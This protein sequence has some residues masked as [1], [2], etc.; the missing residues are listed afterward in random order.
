MI[1]GV[2]PTT[3]SGLRVDAI[4][5]RAVVLEAVANALRDHR[6]LLITFA[7]PGTPIIA[8]RSNAVSLFDR[9]DIVAAD[10]IAMVQGM[11]WLHRLPV[12]RLSFDSTS[13]APPVF[14]L[15]E[16]YAIRV[17]LCGGRPGVAERAA[18]HLKAA[19]SRLRIV[20]T[21]DG[22]TDSEVQI[23]QIRRLDP[24]L[25]ICGMGPI[26]QEW[27]LATLTDW[28]WSGVGI[29]C[30]GYLDQLGQGLQYYPTAINA[31]NL[32]WAYRLYREPRR[33]WRRY[34]LDYPRFAMSLCRAK[35]NLG[36]S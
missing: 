21:F 36:D 31:L 17:V 26:R 2:R 27:F 23:A 1:D 12:V 25:V 29:T 10:G 30:G 35:L 14:R 33:L 22:Y 7:N 28:G 6:R 34:L 4:A 16:Q 11:K 9:F 15:A 13:L 8:K 19:Y 5:D 32:R 3:T 20:A 18:E 24:Q